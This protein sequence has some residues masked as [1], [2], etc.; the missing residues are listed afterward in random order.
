MPPDGGSAAASSAWLLA[1]APLADADGDGIRDGRDRCPLSPDA[2][3]RD[4]DGDGRGDACDDCPFTANPD[5]TDRGGVGAGS[6]PDGIG[7]ACQCGDVSGDG[8]VTTADAL[9]LRR[10]LL[11]PPSATLSRPTLCNVGGSAACTVADAIIVQRA[12]LLPPSATIGQVC[13]PATP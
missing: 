4:Q 8:R 3:Q 1:P 13:I 12:L 7:D 11:T 5:Q 10:S 9:L 6:P 2:G